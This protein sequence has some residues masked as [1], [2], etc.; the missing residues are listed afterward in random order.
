M[1]RESVCGCDSRQM[2]S[3]LAKKNQNKCAFFTKSLLFDSE[4]RSN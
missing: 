1:M 4:L 2:K 3:C